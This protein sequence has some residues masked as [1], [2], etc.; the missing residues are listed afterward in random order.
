[1]KVNTLQHLHIQF[2]YIFGFYLSR[3]VFD[4]LSGFDGFKS[5][6][7]DRDDLDAGLIRFSVISTK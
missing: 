3:I 2:I 4:D 5:V 6:E 7:H 1:M